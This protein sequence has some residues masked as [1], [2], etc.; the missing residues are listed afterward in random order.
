MNTPQRQAAF[1]SQVAEESDRFRTF[2]EYADGSEYEGRADLG[3]TQPGDGPRYKGCGA[4]QVTGRSNY[5]RMSKDLGVDFVNHPELAAAVR[6]QNRAVVLG[7]SQRERG[8]RHRKCRQ[9]YGD[10]ER[11]NSR[12]G[13]P[14]TVLQQRITVAS[15]MRKE[16][17][18]VKLVIACAAPVMTVALSGCSASGHRPTT[19]ASA[20]VAST[21]SPVPPAETLSTAVPAGVD[22]ACEHATFSAQQFTGD[23]TES[24][25]TTV[26]TLSAD[27]TLTSSGGS[28]SGTWSYVPWASTPG[29]SSM[30][31]GEENQCVLWLHWQSPSPPTDLVYFPLKATGTSLELSFVGRGNT[32]TWV[33]PRPAT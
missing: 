20:R 4:I 16:G 7:Y 32:L 29:K 6:V 30:P 19:G 28:Q 26:T 11:W 24:G 2:E 12:V 13:C 10:G 3:N 5:T 8:G 23:W 1:I 31:A 21:L 15:P 33:R 25:G 14:N 22:S 9:D 17:A 27:G 18:M